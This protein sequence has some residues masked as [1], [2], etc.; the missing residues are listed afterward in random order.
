MDA[1]GRKDKRIGLCQPDSRF[2]IRRALAGPDCEHVFDAG[3]AST[4]HDLLAIGLKLRIIEM[5][6]RIDQIHLSRAP[7]GTSS[8]NPASTG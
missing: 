2:E 6:M 8:R 3:C 7:I 5:A 4:I 1:C